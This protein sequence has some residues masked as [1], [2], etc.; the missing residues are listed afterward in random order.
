MHFI[1]RL[2]QRFPRNSVSSTSTPFRVLD[3][4][5]SVRFYVNSGNSKDIMKVSNGVILFSFASNLLSSLFHP[6]FG[7]RLLRTASFASSATG[8]FASLGP[9]SSSSSSSSSTSSTAG[10]TAAPLAETCASN[11]ALSC[12]A[13]DDQATETKAQAPTEYFRKDYKPSPYAI[14][15]VHLDFNLAADSTIVK[16]KMQMLP[17]TAKPG[18]HY[19]GAD[20]VLDGEEVE[21]QEVKING[22]PLAAE[23]YTVR[24]EKLVLPY[25]TIVKHSGSETVKPFDLDTTVRI[26]PVKNLAL[27]G[28]YSSGSDLLCTQ[29]EA[30]GFRRI[31]YFLDRPD[32]LAKYTV[33]LEAAKEQYPI[34]LSNGN[35]VDSGD[36]QGEDGSKRHFA[37][38]NDPFPKPSYLFAVVAGKL[39]FIQSSY[40]TMSGRDVQLG[41]YS[42]KENVGQ[43]EHA[44]YSI[45]ESM[46]WDE[47]TFGLE[48]DLDVY[49]IV[50]TNDFNMGAM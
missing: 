44:M 3:S 13:V 40:K 34:L 14:E 50:A 22:V 24:D 39:G 21:L 41:I 4:L 11:T 36:V 29:C 16:A 20:L 5:S 2:P 32:I 17:N 15:H 31:T 48:C 27:S 12:S 1:R 19:A 30:M 18:A 23:E 7:F 38:W 6:V 10:V 42:N 26:S 49:N 46:K 9:V 25:S 35:Q 8:G 47:E 43:L 28:L 33:R 45:K 37:I